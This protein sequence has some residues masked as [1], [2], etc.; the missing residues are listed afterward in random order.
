MPKS[1]SATLLRNLDHRVA[2]I[3]QILPTLAS[4]DDLKAFAT[5]DD[6]QGELKSYATKDELK[7]EVERYPTK[8][9]LK[10]ELQRFATKEDLL[11]EGERSR[12][13]MKMLFETLNETVNRG[14]DVQ[15]GHTQR[16]E[17]HGARLDGHDGKFG[18][19][20]VRVTAIERP[21]RSR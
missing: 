16:L 13:Y 19:L 15:I 14:L 2:V 4:K 20:D 18:E 7:A 5:K 21:R 6:L 9:D 8:D 11:E 1:E 3:E 17:Q 10:V 12:R